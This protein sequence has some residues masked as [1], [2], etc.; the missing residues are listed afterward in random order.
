MNE[1]SVNKSHIWSYHIDCKK[2]V[3]NTQ[4]NLLDEL[5]YNEEENYLRKSIMKK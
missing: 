2:A 1:C 5:P 3:L 4:Q